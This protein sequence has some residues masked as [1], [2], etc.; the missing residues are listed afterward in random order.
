ML[1][2][3][4][5]RENPEKIKK[6]TQDK[7][8][9]PKIVDKVLAIDK[10]RRVLLQKTDS[11]R[12]E[13]NKLKK[14]EV[15]RGREIKKQLKKLEPSLWDVQKE[16][17]KLI[18]LVPNPARPD[19]K[20]GKDESENEIIK[21]WG[22]PP[23]FDFKPRDHAEI[24][25][26]L[27]LVDVKRAANVS[28]P[29]FG[30]LKNEAVLLEFAL[31]Q[32]AF[33]A[34]IKEG[35]TPLVPPVII[36]EKMMRGLGYLEHG[37]REDMYVFEKDGLVFVGTS[38]QSIIPM[39]ADEIFDEKELPKHYV[40]FSTCFRREA[41]AYGRDTRGIFRVHQF[42]KVEMIAYIK[43]ENS[44]KEHEYLLSLEEGIVQ[45]LKLPYQVVKMCTGDL[46][47]P[48][49]RKYDIEAWF[50]GQNKYREVTSTSTCTDYQARGL[51]IRYRHQGEVDFVHILNGTAV[52]IGRILIAILENY[53]QEDGSVRVPEI[54]Q[55]YVGKKVIGPKN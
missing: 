1:D 31:V 24:G 42:D 49:A 6:A 18:L 44:D 37:G 22:E 32:F 5:I 27:D 2:I 45:K 55:G 46:G 29:R 38:E 54:L 35:F 9:D 43:P 20:V 16:F 21:K 40:G 26:T 10:R 13:R 50:P 23:K 25:E 12:A 51:N 14:E 41:G 3:K 8:L 52:A 15:E 11:L 53:Q 47:H 33:D 4:F 19:V 39:H 34:L 28:G 7:Q 36:K 30:Y 48:A 17:E